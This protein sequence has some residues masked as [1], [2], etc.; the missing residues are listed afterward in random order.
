[1]LSRAFLFGVSGIAM[2]VALYACGGNNGNSLTSV[3]A[4]NQLTTS[5]PIKHVVVIYNENVSFDHYFATYPN[6]TN[7]AGE[8]TFTAAASTPAVNGL[9]AG[10]MANNPNLDAPFRLDR[11]QALTCDMDHAYTDEQK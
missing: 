3:S 8:P 7:P 10:L 1:M 2:A 5:T 9:S 11:S 4:Q 6:A